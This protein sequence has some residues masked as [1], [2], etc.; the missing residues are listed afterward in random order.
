MSPKHRWEYK[1]HTFGPSGPG[2]PLCPWFP[3]LPFFPSSP[4]QNNYKKR[5]VALTHHPPATQLHIRASAF[6]RGAWAQPGHPRLV[7]VPQNRAQSLSLIQSDLMFVTSKLWI[8]EN[9]HLDLQVFCPVV[10]CTDG[11][12]TLS[13]SEKRWFLFHL[14][15]FMLFLFKNIKR[16]FFFS[17]QGP[18]SSSVGSLVHSIKEGP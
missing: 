11:S 18:I 14:S 2:N 3:L 17:N 7:K 9:S 6:Q 16:D 8:S 4:W 1:K 13:I 5:E 15:T 12:D 10:L